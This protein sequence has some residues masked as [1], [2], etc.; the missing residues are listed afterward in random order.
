MTETPDIR[1]KRLRFRSW[2]RG[3]KELDLLLGSFADQELAAMDEGELEQYE[4]L[5]ALPDPLLYSWMT[6]DGTPGPE[7]DHA[8]TR[9]LCA[10]QYRPDRS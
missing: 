3:T 10:F 4:T 6:G 7:H 8:L 2:H 9:R 1:R 5:L